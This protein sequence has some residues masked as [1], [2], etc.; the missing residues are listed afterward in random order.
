M[1]S[2]YLKIVIEEFKK[3][4]NITSYHITYKIA[5]NIT[6]QKWGKI[7]E[8]D[9]LLDEI[10]QSDYCISN[11]LPILKLIIYAEMQ[12]MIFIKNEDYDCVNDHPSNSFICETIPYIDKCGDFGHIES[13]FN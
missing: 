12:C 10:S 1:H 7:I 9:A 8:L 6:Q 13:D 3:L 2:E 5:D 4:N 11:N